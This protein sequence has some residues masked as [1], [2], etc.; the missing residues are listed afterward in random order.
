MFSSSCSMISMPA[1]TMANAIA[2]AYCTTFY[3]LLQCMAC[4]FSLDIRKYRTPSIRSPTS[5]PRHDHNPACLAW[6]E[7]HSFVAKGRIGDRSNQTWC[8]NSENNLH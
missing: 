7:M 1:S 8:R 3:G 4:G 2:A 6:H 5:S